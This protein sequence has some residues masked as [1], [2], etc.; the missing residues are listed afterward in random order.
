[1]AHQYID[2]RRWAHEGTK[3]LLDAAA[4]LGDRAYREP[5]TLP[6]WDR[7]HVLA[8]LAANADALQNLVRRAATGEAIPMYSSSTARAEAIE[9]GAK[10]APPELLGWLQASS[11]QL[12]TAM[13]ALSYQ[14]WEATVVTAQERAVPATEIPWLRAREVF[15]HLVDLKVGVPFAALPEGFLSALRDDITTKRIAAGEE[16]PPITGS[17][18][19]VTAFLAGR[20]HGRVALPDGAPAPALS[21][22]L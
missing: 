2:A 3:L 1:M 22:W 6:G 9:D 18:A 16:I 20:P 15:V 17:A 5:S 10:L 13:N 7:R 4:A 21:P 12:E 19:D 14:Q 11:G 8:H